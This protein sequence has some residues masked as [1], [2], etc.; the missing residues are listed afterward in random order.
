MLKI[1]TCTLQNMMLLLQHN[2]GLSSE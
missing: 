2:L 1:G